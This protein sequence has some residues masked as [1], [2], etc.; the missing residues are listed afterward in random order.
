MKKPVSMKVAKPGEYTPAEIAAGIAS[1]R[2]KEIG[3]DDTVDLSL[4]GDFIVVPKQ[5][6]EHTLNLDGVWTH[7]PVG[8]SH[9]LLDMVSTYQMASGRH[10]AFLHRAHH[11]SFGVDASQSLLIATE[12][13]DLLEQM[14]EFAPHPFDEYTF[15]FWTGDDAGNM[16]EVMVTGAKDESDGEFYTEMLGLVWGSDTVRQYRTP[17]NRTWTREHVRIAGDEAPPEQKVSWMFNDAF[18][19]LLAQPKGITVNKG[20]GNRTA[21]RKGKRV[22]FYSKSEIKIDLD[23]KSLVRPSH[24]TGNGKMMPVYQYRAHLCHSGGTRGCEH[25]WIRDEERENP[26]WTCEKCDR[27]RWHRKSGVRG[28]AELGYVRQTYKVVKG[29][30]Q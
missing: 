26:Y 14:A 23:A 7:V 4:G 11:F 9:R 28:S 30:D 25:V 5:N 6:K 21:I 29:Q 15:S 1:G 16:V 2:M 3:M 12:H 13:K 27:R 24:H 19:L 8:L 18:R 17:T 10:R 20:P 22:T